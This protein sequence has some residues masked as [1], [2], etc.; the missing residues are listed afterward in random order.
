MQTASMTA[1]SS[2][3][4]PMK[5]QLG[6]NEAPPAS[7]DLEVPGQEARTTTSAPP[8]GQRRSAR[9]AA[10]AAAASALEL[11]ADVEDDEGMSN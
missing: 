3:A 7:K 6:Q 2:T 1:G 4:A 5:Q 10:A 8:E 9:A 11:E